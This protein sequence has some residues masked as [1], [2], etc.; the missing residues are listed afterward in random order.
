VD[1][2]VRLPPDFLHTQ[3]IRLLSEKGVGL[4]YAAP[5]PTGSEDWVAALHNLSVCNSI[6]TYGSAAMRGNLNAA[7][8]SCILTSEMSLLPLAGWS[9]WRIAW[10]GWMSPWDGQWLKPDT[11]SNS[12]L[13]LLESITLGSIHALLVAIPSL[14]GNNQPG[15]AWDMDCHPHAG[16]TLW[17]ALAFVGLAVANSNHQVIG[18]SLVILVLL[19]DVVFG[20]RHQSAACTGCQAVEIPLGGTAATALPATQFGPGRDDEKGAVARS[21]AIPK[22]VCVM[23][24]R[25]LPY[26][27]DMPS[28]VRLGRL[29]VTL[30]DLQQH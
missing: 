24:R 26:K 15:S 11:K 12:S 22:R 7:V 5:C 4:A 18:L 23:R 21:L 13:N 28:V 10:S 27:L 8:G 16:P 20:C 25:L 3:A 19:M 30:D 29:A 14:A 6:L 2:D 9:A 17:W 1:S